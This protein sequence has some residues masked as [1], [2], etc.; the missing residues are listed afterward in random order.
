[1][2]KLRKM[3]KEFYLRQV[4]ACW[5][6]FCMMFILPARIAIADVVMTSNPEG[7]ITVTPRGSGTTQDMT[8]SHGSIGNFSDFDIAKNH[9]VTCVQPDATSQALFRVSGNGTEILGTFNA[10]GGIW[11]IDPAGIMVGDKGAINVTSLV[12]SS[13]DMLDADFI[14]GLE[15]GVFPFFGGAEAGNITNEGSITAQRIALI[16]KIVT[17][18]GTLLAQDG[19]AVMAAGENVLISESGSN[20]AVEVFMPEQDISN[21][22]VNHDTGGSIDA[23]HVILAAGD[24]WSSAY[25]SASS[26]GSS[27]AVASVDI[28][29]EGNVIVRDKIEA[30]AIAGSPYNATAT[31]TVDAGGDVEI[32]DYYQKDAGLFALAKFG[33]TNNADITVTAGGDVNV[34]AENAHAAQIYAKAEYSTTMDPENITTNNSTVNV[35]AQGDVKVEAYNVESFAGIEA[36]VLEGTI[37]NVVNTA[38]VNIEAKSVEV[39]SEN[40]GSSE[41]EGAFIRASA[42]N[43][44]ELGGFEGTLTLEDITNNADI[45]ITTTVDDDS[46]LPQFAD[47]GD[48]L[49]ITNNGK[50]GINAEA[51]NKINSKTPVKFTLTDSVSNNSNILINAADDVEVTGY[52]GEALIGAEA[53]FASD[54]TAAVDISADGAVIVTAKGEGECDAVIGAKAT[55]A[56]NSNTADV[57]INAENVSVTAM[58]GESTISAEADNAITDDSENSA[59]VEIYTHAVAVE[60]PIER[61][62]ET[63]AINNSVDTHGDVLVTAYYSGGEA[64]I[65]ARSTNAYNNTSNVL[66]CT[67]GD[68]KVEGFWGGNAKVA[69]E[70]INANLTNTATVGIG[71]RGEEGVKVLAIDGSSALIDA[72]AQLAFTNIAETIVCTQGG[73]QVVDVAG[74]DTA[75]ITAQALDGQIN[76]AYVGICAVDDIFVLA[77]LTVDDLAQGNENQGMGGHAMIKA[78]A[79]YGGTNSLYDIVTKAPPPESTTADAEVVVVSHEGGVAVIDSSGQARGL[80][81]EIKAEAAGTFENTASVGVAAYGDLFS[82]GDPIYE[83]SEGIGVTIQSVGNF[84]TAQITSQTRNGNINTSDTVVCTPGEVYVADIEGAGLASARIE[85]LAG[86]PDNEGASTTQVYAGEV[87]LEGDGAYIGAGYD[88]GEVINGDYADRQDCAE[89][90]DCP[91]EE[92]E[93]ELFAPVAPLPLLAIP[94]IEGC[95]ALILAASAELGIPIET[96]QVAI[97][98]ALALNPSLQPCQACATLLDASSILKDEDGSRMAAMVQAFNTLAPADVPFNPET[99]A[100]IAN[101]FETAAE[102]SLYASVAEYIDAFVLYVSVLETELGS[103]VDNSAA[104]VMGR[105]GSD[106]TTDDN[107]NIANFIASRLVTMETFGG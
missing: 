6:V 34:K 22:L 67:D 59:N 12:A 43:I 69:A 13:L 20:I 99:A 15:S 82:E 106:I 4:V 73:I 29:A 101:A 27:D 52:F 38:L 107:A 70:A 90:P 30:T 44:I 85:A 84:S 104:F 48:V 75:G 53:K 62:F 71:A 41:E 37:Q 7:L 31:I 92:E 51:S 40:Q 100:M 94:R 96:I 16:G 42:K 66:L 45:V 68:V 72:K 5:L 19:Y 88:N 49:V 87:T 25:I 74:Y 21:Y 65:R 64:S 18:K 79:G 105:Y 28:D 2:K 11:L 89:C 55:L 80:T 54:N 3:S 97:G 32:S 24:I 58:A 95:P 33:S 56:T 26:D 10:N 23:Q 91:C 14:S 1:M 50:A 57:V 81:A 86:Y 76:D 9:V 78:T 83:L 63:L 35:T 39:R 102:D 8:A 61:P 93:S 98:N 77:G 103:P 46:D 60:E 47:N 17:N 36:E